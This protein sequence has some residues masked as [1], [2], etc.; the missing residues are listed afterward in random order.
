MN[1]LDVAPRR[2]HFVH[3]IVQLRPYVTRKLS[4]SEA[5]SRL[6]ELA[7]RVASS[8]GAVEYI[9]HRDL[10]QTLALTTKGHLLYLEAMVRELRKRVAKPFTLA[11]SIVAVADGAAV[12]AALAAVREE[13]AS[14]G[15]AKLGEL[16]G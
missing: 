11:G 6:P 10:D 16:G 14:H 4:I 9:E 1:T 12:E 15:A 5:R 8:P 2:P 7:H 3:V 13:Q